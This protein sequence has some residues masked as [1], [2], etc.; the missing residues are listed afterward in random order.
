[1]RARISDQKRLKTS[2]GI[3]YKNDNYGVYI[4]TRSCR[5][6][7]KIVSAVFQFFFVLRE[8]A[9]ATVVVTAAAAAVMAA[10]SR[11]PSSLAVS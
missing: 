5:A 8:F 3:F 11:L 10:P 7:A 2:V 6:R 4:G 1:M 9:T